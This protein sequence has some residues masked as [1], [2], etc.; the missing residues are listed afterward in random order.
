[1][2]ARY[3][4][5]IYAAQ[6]PL[7]VAIAELGTN[8]QFIEFNETRIENT[9]LNLSDKQNDLEIT[10]LPSEITNYKVLETIYNATLQMGAQ[11]IPMSIF[12]YIS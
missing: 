1:M 4:D 7:S 5:L 11:M 10:D 9:L 6:S 12:N 8:D 3:A 2:V